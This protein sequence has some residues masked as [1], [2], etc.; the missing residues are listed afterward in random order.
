MGLKRLVLLTALGFALLSGLGGCGSDI[1]ETQ[2]E[3]DK[4]AA[5]G[6]YGMRDGSGYIICVNYPPC[7]RT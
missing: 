2:R 6:K 4:C 5:Q 7:P 1:S 3:Y